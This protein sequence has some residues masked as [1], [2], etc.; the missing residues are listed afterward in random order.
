MDLTTVLREVDSWPVE[1]RIRLV[2]EVWDRLA[3]GGVEPELTD[4]QKAEFDRRLADLDS[5]P[6]DV[7]TWE[8]IERHVR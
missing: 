8:E 2:Q 6:D 7:V 1:E 5:N 3:D 4:E